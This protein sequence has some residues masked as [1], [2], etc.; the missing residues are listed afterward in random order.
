MLGSDFWW[1]VYLR[2]FSGMDIKKKMVI[3]FLVIFVGPVGTLALIA[4]LFSLEY[5]YI[6]IPVIAGVVLYF[7]WI[8]SNNMSRSLMALTDYA[9]QLTSEPGV[10]DAPDIGP[11]DREVQVLR[12]AMSKLVSSLL[13]EK[14]KME[15]VLENLGEA[16]YVTDENLKVT[17]F[18]RAASNLLGYSK[19]EIVGKMHC[20]DFTQ[21]SDNPKCHTDNCSSIRILRGETP[22]EH[23]EVNMITRSGE[24]FPAVITTSPLYENGTTK[25]VGVLKLVRDLRDLKTIQRYAEELEEANRIKDLFTDVLR[26][27]LM[28]PA[29]NIR[30]LLELA[31]GS[32][33][34]KETEQ[35][36]QTAFNASQTL[37]SIIDNASKLSRINESETPKRRTSTSLKSSRRQSTT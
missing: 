23:R 36:L 21:Y 14:L 18:N 8:F 31:L 5:F 32:V 11:A 20:Y 25:I 26:H 10:P 27:D 1:K 17:H 30:S 37:I 3:G 6:A 4:Y 7:I 9:R 35:L 19:E 24:E 16:L 13:K 22:I 34:D 2:F 12:D 33:E 15:A 28:N 29:G